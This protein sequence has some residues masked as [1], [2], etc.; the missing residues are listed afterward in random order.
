MTRK[1]AT[2]SDGDG[3][4]GLNAAELLAAL[5]ALKKGDFSVQLPID[6]TGLDG[7]I[8]DAFNDVVGIVASFASELQQAGR[9]IGK[10][11]KLAHR[12]AIGEVSGAWRESVSNV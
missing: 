6:L 2:L 10:E 11:G 5:R 9:A 8:A 3:G 7:K 4:R 1:A 12:I